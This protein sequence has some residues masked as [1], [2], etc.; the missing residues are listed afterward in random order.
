M[1]IADAEAPLLLFLF[2][3]NFRQPK[4]SQFY[5]TIFIDYDILGLEVSMNDALLMSVLNGGADLI[6][7]SDAFLGIQLVFITE[8]VDGNSFY[9]FHHEIWTA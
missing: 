3:L 2:D 6:E 5:V 1:G 7:E 4:I 8:L 9:K